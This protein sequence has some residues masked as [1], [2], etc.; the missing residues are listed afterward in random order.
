MDDWSDT[1]FENEEDQEEEEVERKIPA[2]SIATS[3]ESKGKNRIASM[4]PDAH[5]HTLGFLSSKDLGAFLRRSKAGRDE[6]I[7]HL[8]LCR[9]ECKKLLSSENPLQVLEKSKCA[10]YCIYHNCTNVLALVVSLLTLPQW[11]VQNLKTKEMTPVSLKRVFITITP[12]KGETKEFEILPEEHDVA[13]TEALLFPNICSHLRLAVQDHK[14]S[15]VIQF[16]LETKEKVPNMFAQYKLVGGKH[17]F[18][19]WHFDTRLRN[20]W[21]KIATV[22]PFMTMEAR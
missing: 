22:N 15:A 18:S 17:D 3:T 21:T 2:R 1:A 5:G 14:K 10:G 8:H 11:A 16:G 19:N 7:R 9:A 4:A 6:T 20:R 12:Q 13:Y